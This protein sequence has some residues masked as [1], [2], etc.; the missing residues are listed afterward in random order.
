VQSPQLYARAALL[1]GVK[2]V[3]ARH[4]RQA[5]VV[6]QRGPHIHPCAPYVPLSLGAQW[7]HDAISVALLLPQ[8]CC[9]LLLADAAACC[10]S[11]CCAQRWV[12]QRCLL[13]GGLVRLALQRE[14]L[15][16]ALLCGQAAARE[17]VSE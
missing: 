13:A 2:R 14:Q 10:V 15:L 16:V 11:H 5:L 4:V 12:Q 7:C 3:K 17:A 1:L 9:H 8:Q 6:D